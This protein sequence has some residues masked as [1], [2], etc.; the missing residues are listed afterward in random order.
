MGLN[1]NTPIQALRNFP[2]F[3]HMKQLKCYP[4]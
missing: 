3:T 1:G 4:C 2:E